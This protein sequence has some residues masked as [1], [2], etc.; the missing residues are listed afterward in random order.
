[1]PHLSLA[2]AAMP[3]A[4]A[5][6]NAFSS[7][8]GARRD[9]GEPLVY[10][11]S[12]IGATS[13]TL[14]FFSTLS[15]ARVAPLDTPRPAGS[16]LD[17]PGALFEMDHAEVAF[18]AAALPAPVAASGNDAA[19]WMNKVVAALLGLRRH[20]A[21]GSRRISA[22]CGALYTV[23]AVEAIIAATTPV[24]CASGAFLCREIG[25]ALTGL[26]RVEHVLLADDLARE[27]IYLPH[28]DSLAWW[29]ER[30]AAARQ[31]AERINGL[32]RDVSAIP[33]V[34]AIASAI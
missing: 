21:P 17:V 32:S 1:M 19:A 2:Q 25:A 18:I 34:L 13:A 3:G 14:A 23:L 29:N 33:A 22:R 12:S 31:D 8:L 6:P 7:L 26:S 5:R 16:L 27:F 30:I 9:G 20:G 15:A 11:M 24:S 4:V 10:A 28:G